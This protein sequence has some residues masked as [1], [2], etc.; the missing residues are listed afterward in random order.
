MTGRPRRPTESSRG[1]HFDEYDD[2]ESFDP[3]V[4]S[5]TGWRLCEHVLKKKGGGS[6]ANVTK[7]KLLEAS[8]LSLET[9]GRQRFAMTTELPPEEDSVTHPSEAYLR[10]ALWLGRNL[11]MV[12]EELAEGLDFFRS[13]FLSEVI[14]DILHSLV[15]HYLL[16]FSIF[17]LI[18]ASCCFDYLCIICLD[19]SHIFSSFR[20][21]SGYTGQWRL[22]S[23]TW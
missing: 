15:A 2:F 20:F 4:K 3:Q 17:Q 9:M 16:F 23:Q 1:E 18:C 22:G 11:T 10:G 8:L 13:K 12:I 5:L 19:S 21:P 7:E 6:I 14:R